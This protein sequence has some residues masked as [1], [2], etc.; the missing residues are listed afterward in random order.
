VEEKK[1]AEKPKSRLE[2]KNPLPS[3][4]VPKPNKVKPLLKPITFTQHFEDKPVRPAVHLIE[5]VNM[6]VPIKK[7]QI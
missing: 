5:P 4:E 2:K 1:A 6:R 3:K 7:P